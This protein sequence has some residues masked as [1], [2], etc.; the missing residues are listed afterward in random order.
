LVHFFFLS[1][2]MLGLGYSPVLTK[3]P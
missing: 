3:F 2:L 1:D